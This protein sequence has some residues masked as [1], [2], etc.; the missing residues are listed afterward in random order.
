VEVSG[1]C[2]SVTNSAKLAVESIG[3]ASPATFDNPSPIT[4]NDFS[5]ATP[6]PSMI[7]VAC[8]PG[9]LT[10]L[11]VTIT[12]LN[13]TYASD[14]DILLVSPSGQAVMLMSDAGDASVIDGATLTFSDAAANSVS[15][16]G[17]IISGVYKPTNYGLTDN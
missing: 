4:I 13:H 17:P 7:E 2:S 15:E 14:I 16:A 1:Q 8:V 11:I 6:Y 3:L 5:P 12:N 10:G 9:P